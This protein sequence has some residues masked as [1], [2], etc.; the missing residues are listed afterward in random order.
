MAWELS[1]IPCQHEM[2]ALVH[3]K[4]NSKDHISIWY[5]RD[6]YIVAY[7]D[8]IMLVKGKR[9]YNLSKYLLEEP[10]MV[11]KRKGRP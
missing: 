11:E 3:N 2:C 9:F 7:K 5:H 1:G 4:E 6:M 8:K 10:P